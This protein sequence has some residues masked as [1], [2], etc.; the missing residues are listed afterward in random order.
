MKRNRGNKITG[1]WRFLSITRVMVKYG[2]ADLTARFLRRRQRNGD[3]PEAPAT[4]VLRIPSPVRLRQ[5]LEELGPSFIKLGQLMSTRA[6]VF[7]PAYIEEFRKLQ[8]SV[9]PFPYRQACRVIETELKRPL[10]EVFADFEPEPQGSASVAQVHKATLYN[11]DQVAVKVIRPGIDRIIQKDIRLMHYFAAKLEKWFEVARLLGAVNL[12]QEFERTIFR[13]LDM[14][15]E[16]GSIE[17]FGKLFEDSE[18]IHIP[19]VHWDYTTR[20][21]LVM[22]HLDG[23]K[24]DNIEAIIGYDISPRDIAMIGLRSFSRQLMEF[25]FFHADPHPANTIV[26]PDGRVG[27]VDFGITGYIDEEMMRQIANLF[28]GYAEHDYDMIME[29]LEAAGLL[30]S[31]QVDLDHFRR[32]L[33]EISEPFYGRALQSVSVREVYDQ[34]IALVLTYRI[35]L[36][37]NLLLLLK[38]FIQA[39]ALGKILNS[40]ANILEVTR[41]YA[42][43]LVQKGYDTHKLFKTLGRE[44][45]TLSQYARRM[46]RYVNDILRQA[47]SGEYHL[48][49]RHR[50]FEN[51]DRKIERGI[52]RLTVGA[53]ISAS[54]IAASLILNSSQK[55]IEFT[56]PFF[57]QPTLSITSVLGITGYV[58]ATVLGIWLIV[59]IFRSGRL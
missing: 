30:D 2:L 47:A 1:A 58:I 32:D 36:P 22:E 31:R 7:P 42:E 15:I 45:R 21:I 37:R 34:V 24:M 9:A 8:D 41:P 49:F 28:L 4:G 59:S 43:R 14:Y 20:E 39:E 55:V 25:G 35:R 11:G 50:G 52:N 57:G 48:E 6:D 12:V 26:M 10:L 40:D 16:A 13:E 23:C 27:L 51:F 53:V 54:T 38:T 3:D 33:M 18:E 19:Q 29:A 5:A 17:K 44:T 56:L 46:P